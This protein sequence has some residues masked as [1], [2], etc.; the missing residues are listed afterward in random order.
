MIWKH[1][2]LY[3][4]SKTFREYSF[5]FSSNGTIMIERRAIT[6]SLDIATVI[7]SAV[8]PA[9]HRSAMDIGNGNGNGGMRRLQLQD[10]PDAD[11]R[12]YL[13]TVKLINDLSSK[14]IQTTLNVSMTG[15]RFSSFY[16]LDNYPELSDG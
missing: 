15:P 13:I 12:R 5:S 2:K 14:E 8:N 1:I 6:E 11:H 10:G 7:A 3:A 9:H 16:L 4:S